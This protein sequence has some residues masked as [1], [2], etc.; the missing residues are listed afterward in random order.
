MNKRKIKKKAKKFLKNEGFNKRYLKLEFGKSFSEMRFTF[1]LDSTSRYTFEK[2]TTCFMC[3]EFKN[4]GGHVVE[5]HEE[6]FQGYKKKY[7]K[8]KV[9]SHFIGKRKPEIKEIDR[10]YKIY[11]KF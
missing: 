9:F 11:Q 4:Y 10:L 7:K 6:R 3:H 5:Y 2:N 8:R 1:E